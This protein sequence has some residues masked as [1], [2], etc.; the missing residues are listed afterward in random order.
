MPCVWKNKWCWWARK[1]LVLKA[2]LKVLV[3]VLP[4]AGFSCRWNANDLPLRWTLP[5]Y[6]QWPQ[7][8]TLRSQT[9]CDSHTHSQWELQKWR[10]F[11]KQ[12]EYI[13]SVR[14]RSFAVRETWALTLPLPPTWATSSLSEPWFLHPWLV[15]SCAGMGISLSLTSGRESAPPSGYH[16][17]LRPIIAGAQSLHSYLQ[18]LFL[19]WVIQGLVWNSD[20]QTDIP[21]IMILSVW[22]GFSNLHI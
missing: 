16:S 8:L 2:I 15:P 19:K 22:V 21:E 12:R 6:G 3:S 4:L 1:F 9:G 18:T 14:R 10:D 5:S 11:R 13:S 17:L 20:S 7:I